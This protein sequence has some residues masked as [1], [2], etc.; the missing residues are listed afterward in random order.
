MNPHHA[1]L[2]RLSALLFGTVMAI[3]AAEA[4]VYT[5]GSPSGAGQPCTHGTIQSAINAANSNPGADT[6]RLTRSLTYQPEAN[7]IATSQELTI[8]GG[9]ATCTS[10]ADTTNTVVSGTGGAQAPVFTIDTQTGG[11]VHLRR[12]TIS[13]G[14]VA[15]NGTGGGIRL[16]G[17]GILQIDDSTIT[18]NI[19][20][21]GG[22]IYANGT[23]SD[24]ELVIGANVVI[25][26]N[27]ARYDGGGIYSS[28]METT[29]TAPGSFLVRNQA[30]GVASGTYTG[31]YGGGLYIRAGA[32][33]SYAYI[34]SGAPIFGP[35]YDN[36][37]R[38][39]GGVAIGG[40]ND[41]AG[42]TRYAELQLFTTDPARQAAIRANRASISGGGIH[43]RGSS[44]TLDGTVIAGANIWNAS[45]LDNTAPDAAAALVDGYLDVNRLP[46]REG[47]VAC[48]AGI[49]CGRIEGNAAWDGSQ[50]TNGAVV[51]N[52]GY[53]YVGA[54]FG[55]SAPTQ[56]PPGGFVVRGNRGGTLI[57]ST[58]GFTGLRNAVVSDNQTSQRLIESS[59]FGLQLIDTTVTGNTIGG[60][61]VLSASDVYLIIKRSLLW[62]PGRTTLLRSGGTMEVDNVMASE[63]TSIG[64]NF[65]GGGDCGGGVCAILA[66]PRFIDPARGDY[67]L[68]AGSPAVDFAVAIPGDDRDAFALA[69]DVDLPIKVNGRGPRDLGAFERQLLLP[70]VLNGDFESDLRLWSRYLGAWDGAQN[71]S[72]GN[73]SGSWSFNTSGGTVQRFVV[74]EQCVF[75]PGPGRYSLNGRGRTGS[76]LQPRDGARIEWEYRRNGTD[77]C[78]G[79][80]ANAFGDLLVGS[81]TSWGSAAQPAV[82]EVT[83]QDFGPNTS[84][85]I[86]LVAVEGNISLATSIAA[87]FDGI[88]LDVLSFDDLI[89]RD[90][91]D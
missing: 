78:T 55:A 32:R 50:Y 15:G 25:S 83:P 10:T 39:G 17:N 2:A 72:G 46:W 47:A 48:A 65:G 70:M 59:G 31:G 87:W 88:T 77:T 56:L 8:E 76:N 13:G 58:N 5:V 21:Y 28:G 69:R 85:N 57:R 16:T 6:V 44:G 84:I 62:Q 3:P 22:G 90:G 61:Q 35:I 67:R 7:T 66:D 23:G 1:L 14:D 89:F 38:Y 36:T 53:I 41:N 40:T 63:I 80:T 29:M 11:V 52:G 34:G 37:A 81:G 73:G 42:T 51:A 26:N 12:L 24:A 43:I 20:G 19:A 68:R 74:G 9:Y 45:L 49:D 27:T 33:S 91:F 60:A 71:A 54:D 4:A 30:T 79:N 18:N 64:G 86:R 82:I 75:L